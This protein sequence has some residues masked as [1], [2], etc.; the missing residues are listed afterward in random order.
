LGCA[1][2]SSGIGA[3]LVSTRA[4]RARIA[5]ILCACRLREYSG[6]AAS[7]AARILAIRGASSA[8]ASTVFAI[9]RASSGGTQTPQSVRSTIRVA[10]P[11]GRDISTGTPMPMVS[12]SFDGMTVENTGV[13]RNG[14]SAR[15]HRLHSA[16]IASLG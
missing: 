9:A 6:A 13:S 10:S 15:S 8:S 14:I 12:K 2:S 4:S 3:R 5:S 7:P 11:L 1:F 16:G